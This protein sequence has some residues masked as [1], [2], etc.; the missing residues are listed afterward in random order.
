MGPRHHS[1]NDGD[2]AGFAR[3]MLQTLAIVLNE[4]GALH[5]VAGWITAYREFGKKNH[6]RARSL[7]VTRK[8]DDFRCIAREI[9]HRGIDL[10]QRNLHSS[11][12]KAG[13][14]RAKSGRV[15]ESPRSVKIVRQARS[16]TKNCTPRTIH[17]GR[18]SSV[19]RAADS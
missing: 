12:V 7:G 19:G 4:R 10:P 13:G 14:A 16:A 15:S 1:A 17:K 5:Q 3:N 6:S 9:T 8:F 18:R 11:S 2:A